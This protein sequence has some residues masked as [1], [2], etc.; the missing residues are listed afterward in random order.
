MIGAIII[1]MVLFAG[2]VVLQATGG[3]YQIKRV[4]HFQRRRLRGHTIQSILPGLLGENRS[5]KLKVPLSEVRDLIITLQLGTS[6]QATMTG[7]LQKAAEQFRGR[8]V[9][10]D[11]LNRHVEA[12]LHSVG[13][14][15]VLEGLAEDFDCPQLQEVLERVRMAEDGGISYTQVLA[16]SVSTIEEDIRGAVEQ[17]IQKAPTRLTL[18]MVVG[19]FFPALILGLLPI[20]AVGMGQ[21]RLP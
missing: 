2:V 1:V 10:G 14:Q 6:M 15:A 9:L 7:S 13:P 21:M 18:P 3:D 20:V 5:P 4:V 12:K 16:V 19:V 11:R 17:E 8:G